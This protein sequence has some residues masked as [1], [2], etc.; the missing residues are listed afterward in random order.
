MMLGSNEFISVVQASLFQLVHM[1]MISGN[2]LLLVED[3]TLLVVI[4]DF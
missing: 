4:L 1:T 3:L 2:I